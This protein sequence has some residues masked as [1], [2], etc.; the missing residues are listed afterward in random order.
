MN[1]QGS[2]RKGTKLLQKRQPVIHPNAQKCPPQG[3]NRAFRCWILTLFPSAKKTKIRVDLTSGC[4]CWSSSTSDF[5]LKNPNNFVLFIREEFFGF[6]RNIPRPAI[7]R[8]Q[9][10]CTHR[11][12]ASPSCLLKSTWQRVVV[13]RETIK[14]LAQELSCANSWLSWVNPLMVEL[15]AFLEF[16]SRCTMIEWQSIKLELHCF[17][18]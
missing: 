7:T 10:G 9:R 17:I 3:Y 15:T 12:G 11:P 16:H 4:W 5:Y 14:F 1:W 8:T 2:E 6:W 18:A 13:G